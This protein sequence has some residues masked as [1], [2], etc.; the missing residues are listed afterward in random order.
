MC[1][2]P[3]AVEAANYGPFA[4]PPAVDPAAVAPIDAGFTLT[5]EDQE[6]FDKYFYFHRDSTDFATAFADLYECDSYARAVGPSS[7]YD[8]TNSV[9]WAMQQQLI[10]QHGLAG[11]A[12]GAVGGIIGGL[13]AAEMAA[14][15]QRK[16]RRR[17]MR[18]CMAFKEYQAYGVPKSLWQSFNSD[19]RSI[20]EEA[21]VSYL[22]M[23]AKLASG[24]KPSIGLI[25]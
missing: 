11:A 15:E 4:T 3:V 16:M 18:T 13:I 2:S 25:P 10:D 17:T 12:G 7:K 6:G 5:P 20:K 19:S 24:P 22:Q 9:V 1:V 21:R 23:Q 8:P 14:A